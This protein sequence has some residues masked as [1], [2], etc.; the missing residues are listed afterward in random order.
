MEPCNAPH[1]DSSIVAYRSKLRLGGVGRKA[2]QSAS[3]VRLQHRAC[4]VQAMSIHHIHFEDL[5]TL[6][7]D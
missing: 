3:K 7:A 5:T 4:R 2:I 6:C 1:P